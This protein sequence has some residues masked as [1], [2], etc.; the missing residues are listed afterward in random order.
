MIALI[1]Q[2]TCVPK[3]VTKCVSCGNHACSCSVPV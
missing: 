1:P 2:A 3:L